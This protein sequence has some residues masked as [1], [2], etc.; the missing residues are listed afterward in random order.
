MSFERRFASAFAS[1]P[2]IQKARAMSTHKLRFCYFALCLWLSASAAFAQAP[3]TTRPA[4]NMLIAN[5]AATNL[6]IGGATSPG[7]GPTPTRAGDLLYFNGTT[8]VSLAGNN[9]GTQVL[10]ENATGVP[11]WA[12]V[13][14][15]GTVTSVT[16]GTGLTGGT[17]TTSGT[18]GVALPYF[19]ANLS[20]SQT[21]TTATLTKVLFNTKN[22]DSNTWYDNTTNYRFTP[23]LAGKYCVH[24]SL[25]CSGT[26][27]SECAANIYKDGSPYAQEASSGNTTL[28]GSSVDI[29]VTMN[30]ST[31]YAEGWAYITCTGTCA[32]VGGSAPI[33]SWFEA[34][35]ILP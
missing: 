8:W 5:C 21:I 9:S 2:Q 12:T 17:F 33:L 6:L 35:Y 26:V 19:N 27:V 30:G 23:Q 32:A 16:C 28:S 14:G 1:V 18:C 25:F 22:S 20:S 13:S 11:S 29:I 10:E 24:M 3:L 34:Q 4:L 7:C 31:D 15:T